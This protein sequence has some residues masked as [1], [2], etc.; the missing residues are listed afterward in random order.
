MTDR[1]HR[2]ELSSKLGRAIRR[3]WEFV[4]AVDIGIEILVILFLVVLAILA[5]GV[6]L[7][8]CVANLLP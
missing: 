8:H 4:D 2:G 5:V 6:G 7:F 3:I 1:R